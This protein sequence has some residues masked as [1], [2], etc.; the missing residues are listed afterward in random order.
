[1]TKLS[2]TGAGGFLGGAL[3]A[4]AERKGYSVRVLDRG[5][6][7]LCNP[8]SLQGFVGEADVI[9]HLAGKNKANETEM[10]ASN[11]AATVGLLHAVESYGK[12]RVRLIYAS[13]MQVYRPTR[14]PVQ[15]R[16]TDSLGFA[17]PFAKSK[18]LAE[19]CVRKWSDTGRIN[20][21]IMRISNVYGPGARSGYNSVVATFIEAAIRNS[22]LKVS[23]SGLDQRDFVF[24]DD[25]VQAVLRL[26]ELKSDGTE[27]FNVCTG[28]ASSIRLLAENIVR[29]FPKVAIMFDNSSDG[30]IPSCLIG[31]PT[32]LERRT[33]FRP[34]TTLDE[35]LRLTIG[36]SLQQE[37]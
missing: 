31:D 10:L 37:T 22:P 11:T 32:R 26:V 16:E 33:G 23:N 28:E 12:D 1:M 30:H 21:L 17:T 34:K 20:G 18:C 29:F 3:R 14:T 8:E 24:L 25:V 9:I 5:Q 19:G 13:S 15:I 2:I 7:N 27:T 35:G 36:D 6:E 4:S